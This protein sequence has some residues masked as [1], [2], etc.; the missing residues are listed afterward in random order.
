MLHLM[1]SQKTPKTPFGARL[2]NARRAK[3]M[4]QIQLAK[5]TGTTQR[6]ISYYEATGGNPSSEAVAKLAQ[7]LGT[8]TDQLLGLVELHEPGVEPTTPDEKR[9]WRRFR[10]LLALPEKDRRAVMRM[11]D[12]LTKAHPT[13][14]DAKVS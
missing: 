1:P 5:A 9:L 8:S 12:S 2:I 14:S 11:L 10:Q 3:G 13:R 4:T 7:A 6:A